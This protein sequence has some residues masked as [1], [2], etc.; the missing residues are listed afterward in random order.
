MFEL[1]SFSSSCKFPYIVFTNPIYR[2]AC[3]DVCCTGSH[4]ILMHTIF[5]VNGTSVSVCVGADVMDSGVSFVF[6]FTLVF[7][8]VYLSF[9]FPRSALLQFGFILF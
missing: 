4:A 2:C 3:V 1:A 7:H 6:S 5:D 8:V 9:F